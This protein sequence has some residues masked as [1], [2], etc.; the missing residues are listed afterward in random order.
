MC[1]VPAEEPSSIPS[2][3]LGSSEPSVTPAP[4]AFE[5]SGLFKHLHSHAYTMDIII[6]ITL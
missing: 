5:A 4:G 6:K 1:T 2:P 3:M